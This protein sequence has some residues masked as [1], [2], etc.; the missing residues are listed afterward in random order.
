[1]EHQTYMIKGIE[2]KERQLFKWTRKTTVFITKREADGSVSRSGPSL[3]DMTCL[4]YISKGKLQYATDGSAVT[5][6]DKT[7][8]PQI[9][10]QDKETQIEPTDRFAY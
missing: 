4:V 9:L 6:Y 8:T 3:E 1:M 10:D 2:L 7:A 5:M